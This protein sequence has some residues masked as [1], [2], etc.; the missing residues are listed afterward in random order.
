MSVI[1]LKTTYSFYWLFVVLLFL[2]TCPTGVL[3]AQNE[4]DFKGLPFITNYGPE[5]YKAGIQNWDIIQDGRGALF[6]ANNLG[7][8]E[9]EGENWSRY[10]INNTKVRSVLLGS[11]GKIYVGSQADFG[12]LSADV[13]GKLVYTSLADSLPAATRGFDETWKVF[14]IGKK[15]Y[16]CTFEGIFVYDGENIDVYEADNRLEISFQ[17]DNL[18]YTYAVDRGL[19]LFDEG[20]FDLV[21]NGDFFKDKR[22]S[23]IMKYDNQ[24]LMI[25]T[26]EHGAFLYNGTVKPFQFQGDFWR[27]EFLINH[28]TR[29]RNGNIAIGTQNAGLF[30]IS[31][32]GNRLL[33]LSKE[34]GLQD[35][36]I[37]YIYEDNYD[38]LWLAKNNGLSRVDLN[39][40][41]TFIDDRMGISGA[42]Y[43]ALKSGELV[44]L[45]TNNGLFV[46]EGDKIEPIVGIDGQ[47]YN[48]QRIQGRILVGHNSGTY[49]LEGKTAV[50]I[51]DENGA[52]LFRSIPEEPSLLIQ[53]TYTGLNLFEWLGSDL[54]FKQK[55]EGF[56]ESSRVME[57]DGEYLWVAHG[58]KG[59]FKLKFSP[60]YTQVIESKLY[61]NNDGL[62]TN[63]LNNVFKIS[64]QLVFTANAGFYEYS[65]DQ[66]RFVS[67][68]EYN[69]LIDPGAMLV[70]M[71]ADEVGN[72]Y[73]I[74]QNMLGIIKPQP[75]HQQIVHT[76]TFNKIRRLWNDDLAN[77]MVLDNQHI[78]IGGKQGFI[79]YSPQLDIPQGVETQIIFSEISSKG[80]QDSI[81]FLGNKYSSTKSASNFETELNYA[82][83][84]ISF[85]YAAPHFE[86]EDEVTY[87]YKLENYDEEWSPWSLENRKEY[88]NLRE[89]DYSFQV[90]ARDIFEQETE[91]AIFTFKIKP[92]IYRSFFAY[93]FYTL[94]G[95]FLLFLGFRWLDKRHQ[96]AQSKLK[97]EKDRAL[98]IKDNEI[99][100]I[101][102]RTEEEIIRLKNEKLQNEIEHKN[103]EL[104]SSAMHLIQKNQLLNTIKATLKNLSKDEK[105]KQ[106]NTQL[107]KLIKSIDKDLDGGDEWSQ[108]SENFDQVHGNF[109]TRLKEKYPDLTPQEIKFSAYIRMNLNTKEI[110]NL[111]GISVRGVE[112]GRYRVR[113]KLKLERK[114]NLSD[115]LL[116]F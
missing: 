2:G 5:R 36:T 85:E 73:F 13:K 76:A 20:K 12:F 25:T 22:I 70:D 24:Q 42:G 89:G 72:V 33:H 52:W 106:L 44:Y 50:K 34:E 110:A 111:L 45:G 63:V 78:L 107:G 23:S 68:N 92:P 29:L 54:V 94:G 17:V 71:E 69:Q 43:T 109:I 40:P 88:T 21:Q 103:Q 35:L 65:V 90:R 101:T 10:G 38:G 39:S 7:L 105:T 108:F 4:E 58:Y 116:R 74:E 61:N 59:I 37:N 98:E 26:F 46:W 18:L 49:Y 113:K 27:N 11:D 86:S 31:K 93:V 91:P 56:G 28:A 62:P 100:T 112:I 47:V 15:I 60:D 99:E 48:I 3:L 41:F 6:V 95:G 55:I 82:Q 79:H 51:H 114:E 30:I 87:Q 96:L 53:G 57:F 1:K 67:N 64:N 83:N 19:V 75:N 102:Q 66:D 81:L 8:L 80:T 32:E 115:F 14:E 97:Q 77:I 16:F 104:T 84:S 9:F